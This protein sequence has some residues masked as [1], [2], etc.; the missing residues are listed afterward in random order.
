MT[1][2]NERLIVPDNHGSVLCTTGIYNHALGLWR[3]KKQEE[4][5]Q[6]MLAQGE[7]FPTKKHDGPVF[8]LVC[9]IT[10]KHHPPHVKT[11]SQISIDLGVSLLMMKRRGAEAS[12]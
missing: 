5:W 6:Q 7:S 12:K 3:G 10:Y 11:F 9:I 1:R 2:L 4:D 8:P